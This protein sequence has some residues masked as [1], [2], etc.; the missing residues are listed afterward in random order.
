MPR[1]C[2]CDPILAH[3]PLSEAMACADCD[4]IFSG[5]A[6]RACPSCTSTSIDFVGTLLRT[7]SGKT[8]E[9]VA[10]RELQ[11]LHVLTS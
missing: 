1:S 10:L 2:A 5:R 4:T 7:R 9:G 11:R 3:F 8:Y 6:H